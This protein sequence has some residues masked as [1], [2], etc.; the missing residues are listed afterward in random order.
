MRERSERFVHPFWPFSPFAYLCYF[1]VI[2]METRVLQ[3][4]APLGPPSSPTTSFIIAVRMMATRIKEKGCSGLLPPL[5]GHVI[6]GIFKL[7]KDPKYV[8]S[9]LSKI[10]MNISRPSGFISRW[11]FYRTFSTYLHGINAKNHSI[12]ATLSKIRTVSSIVALVPDD[13]PP[14][15]KELRFFPT[16]LVNVDA[17]LHPS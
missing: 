1:F 13:I 12:R 9:N 3:F 15:P 6:I 2:I 11:S 16:S 8:K 7:K 17:N 4:G 10:D 5:D 14:T